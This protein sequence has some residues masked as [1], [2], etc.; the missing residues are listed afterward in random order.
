MYDNCSTLE[1][2]KEREKI[3]KAYIDEISTGVDFHHNI[4]RARVAA[5]VLAINDGAVMPMPLVVESDGNGAMVLDGHHRIAAYQ[6]IGEQRIDA[7]VI[8]RDDFEQMIHKQFNGDIPS[9]LSDL[10]DHISVDGSPY[11]RIDNQMERSKP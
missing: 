6:E 11:D 5:I 7:W 3:I 4:D 2:I 8:S 9:R 1:I 10:D